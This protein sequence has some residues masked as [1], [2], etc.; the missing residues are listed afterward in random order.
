MKDTNF[1]GVLVANCKAENAWQGT[2]QHFAL[3]TDDPLALHKFQLIEGGPPSYNNLR[4]G[5]GAM[6]TVRRIAAVFGVNTDRVPYI[7]VGVKHEDPCG[8]AV[9]FDNPCTAI[10][11]MVIGDRLAIFGGII[12]TN[13]PIGTQEAKT[14][15]FYATGENAKGNPIRRLIDVIM[16]PSFSQ[17]AIELLKR[18]KGR[19][20][21]LINKV[22]ARLNQDS[23]DKEITVRSVCGG[24][25]QQ[26]N[27]SLI[28]D[29][30]HEKLKKNDQ[31][32]TP[33]QKIDLLLAWAVCATSRSNTITLAL[34]SMIIGNGSGGKSR[35]AMTENAIKLARD[36]GHPVAGAVA[37]SDSF[38]PYPDGPQR[39]IDANVAIIFT[40]FGSAKDKTVKETILNAGVIL[41]WGPDS[42]FRI[43]KH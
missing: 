17:E 6:Q 2:A 26:E 25:L 4:D 27:A 33:Q 7:A 5:N 10:E 9:D 8:G 19:C 38:F 41:W 13:F 37:V 1:P 28:L 12:C 43:F 20:K 3:P 39:L 35:V 32:L 42:L 30:E 31:T 11:K 24:Y 29:L 16:A 15:L 22:L 14:L 34:D 23:V 40:T 21:L 36:S 18:K